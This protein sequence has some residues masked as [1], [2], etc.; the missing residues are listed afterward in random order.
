MSNG[1][2]S[3]ESCTENGK[4]DRKL[5]W[6]A[7]DKAVFVILVSGF[8]DLRC[9]LVLNAQ[10]RADSSDSLCLLVV[11]IRKNHTEVFILD[12]SAV[13]IDNEL[14]NVE[15]FTP[16]HDKIALELVQVERARV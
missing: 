6:D 3:R 4:F 12:K 15:L 11:K 9:V 16:V 1:L 7:T 8:L 5:S 13:S 10:L 14:L 2:L